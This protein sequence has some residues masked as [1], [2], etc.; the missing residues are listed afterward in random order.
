MIRLWIILMMPH[1]EHLRESIWRSSWL[2]GTSMLFPFCVDTLPNTYWS[3]GY[4]HVFPHQQS[5]AAA[6]KVAV[7]F[8]KTLSA[9]RAAKAKAKRDALA[10]EAARA[11]EARALAAAAAL[12]AQGSTT[13]AWGLLQRFPIF[14]TQLTT[15]PR[16]LAL[17]TM[18]RSLYPRNNHN[19]IPCDF[20][21]FIGW[22]FDTRKG[23]SRIWM[24]RSMIYYGH[25]S[26]LVD[27]SGIE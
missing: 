7:S 23:S 13:S 8:R 15:R 5:A 9:Q 24:L 19:L 22:K 16:S 4:R 26:A 12:A 17:F 27:I 10:A 2:G 18:Y 25:R 11:N 14:F 6:A 20:R 3:L 1:L 21:F